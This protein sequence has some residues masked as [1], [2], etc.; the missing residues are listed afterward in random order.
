MVIGRRERRGIDELNAHHSL[1]PPSGQAG[2]TRGD[3]ARVLS[4][5]GV[6][7]GVAVA[8]QPDHRGGQR[9]QGGRPGPAADEV[10]R[11]AQGVARD[12][13]RQGQGPGAGAVVLAVVDGQSP[14]RPPAQRLGARRSLDAGPRQRQREVGQRVVA[15][16][17][18][19]GD[20]DHASG[21]AGLPVSRAIGQPKA[22]QLLHPEQGV[23]GEEAPAVRRARA[24]ERAAR[25]ARARPGSGRRGDA[26]PARRPGSVRAGE[27]SR[28]TGAPAT[29][30]RPR[31][32]ATGGAGRARWCDSGAPRRPRAVPPV[33]TRRAADATRSRCP[34]RRA[35]PR[36]NRRW[37]RTPPGAPAGW[38]R[39]R[40]A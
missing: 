18:A 26:G 9:R 30:A 8:H 10:A 4:A 19:V 36:R 7:A 11:A 17:E 5:Q 24:W 20:E 35:R 25:P 22:G 6:D 29:R 37:P 31:S 40:A 34:R 13:P 38:P 32:H 1:Q 39:P 14:R 28:H 27:R 16:G 12:Q 33:A 15:G 23:E 3:G 2:Q 21:P